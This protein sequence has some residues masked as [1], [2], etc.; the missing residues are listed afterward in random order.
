MVKEAKKVGT[1]YAFFDCR[2]SR[3]EIEAELPRIREMVQTPADLELTLAEGENLEGD[4]EARNAL[5][6][7][8]RYSLGRLPPAQREG[9]NV[10]Y[11][12]ALRARYSN[13]SN[14]AAATKLTSLM[15][16]TYLSSPLWAKKEEFFGE[17]VYKHGDRYVHAH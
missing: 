16:C 15:N 4:S 5:E 13:H 9:T 6:A 3:N 12:Y 1:A 17:T 11:G 14:D 2:Y 7:A 10:S 8:K